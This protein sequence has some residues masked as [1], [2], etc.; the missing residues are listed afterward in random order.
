[1]PIPKTVANPEFARFLRRR[2]EQ[3]GLTQAQQAD[4]ITKAGYPVSANTISRWEID[5]AVPALKE[6]AYAM[7]I[8]SAYGVSL[9]HLY[10]MSG[11]TQGKMLS[12]DST[13]DIPDELLELLDGVT[14]EQMKLI[15]K[16]VRAIVEE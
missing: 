12:Q 14:P 15:I 7:I 16:V 3:D 13:V 6:P 11:L 8:A 2:R 5:G 10:R 4:I 9:G 1:M